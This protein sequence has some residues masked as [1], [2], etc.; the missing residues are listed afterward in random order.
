MKKIRSVVSLMLVIVLSASCLVACGH[1]E[2]NGKGQPGSGDPKKDIEIAYWNAGLGDQW[3]KDVITAFEKEYP[4]YH[5]Y[6][7]AS[8]SA[9][10]INSTIDLDGNT[11]DLYFT[12]ERGD[13]SWIEPLD[14]V[15]ES[16]ADGDSKPLIDKFNANYLKNA[17][18]ADGHFYQITYG[19]G[20]V[21][22]VYNKELFKK[23]G[24]TELPRTTNELAVIC[25]KLYSQN[26]TPICHFSPEGY[27]SYF[28]DALIY[29]YDR[30]AYTENFYSCTGESGTSPSKEVFTKKD[31]RYAV[32][33]AYEKILTTEYV[34]EGSNSVDHVTAQTQFLNDMAAMMVN[35]SWVAN[36]MQ[37]VEGNM[38]KFAM[39]R[40]PVL[41]AIVDKLTTVKSDAQ[42]RKVITA[43]D[44]VQD[45]EKKLSDYQSGENYNVEGLEVSKA[46]WD[47]IYTARFTIA[48]N[49]SGENACIP[50][51]SENIEGAKKFLSFLYSDAGY[52]VYAKALKTP[53]P[54]TFS[55][56]SE[57]DVSDW[58]DFQK[59]QVKLLDEAVALPCSY[60]ASRHDIF[61]A[62]GATKYADVPYVSRLCA[63]NKAD[64]KNAEQIWEEIIAKVNDN[65]ENKWLANIK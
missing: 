24:I 54:M 29:Q 65:Y 61:K 41:S 17:K 19:G 8:A 58:N 35:G 48:A 15:L 39:M 63:S 64:R 40:M 31:G 33:K 55:D 14:D 49:Y 4:E 52:K 18:A 60:V 10:T 3:L 5:V 12:S 30:E 13:L 9:A 46:D 32:L 43:I 20:I 51:Y 53:M 56:G 6:Y 59:S 36:E 28:S 44:Q 62:G 37:S 34:M 25:D 16:T 2:G 42:L 27:Y 11:V 57:L 23:A 1:K 47:Y 38:D 50:K 22:I 7:T 26:I 21:G 45:G